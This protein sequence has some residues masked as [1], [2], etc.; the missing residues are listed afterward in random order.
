MTIAKKCFIILYNR[1]EYGDCM[2][3]QKYCYNM[4]RFL[5]KFE[6]HETCILKEDVNQHRTEEEWTRKLL[7]YVSMNDIPKEDLDE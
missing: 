5:V 6:H 4:R 1:L 7:E 2:I 3:I